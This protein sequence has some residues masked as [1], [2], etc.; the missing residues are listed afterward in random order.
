MGGVGEV[1][2]VRDRPL[3]VRLDQDAAGKPGRV[4]PPRKMLHP[5]GCRAGPA[6]TVSMATVRSQRSISRRPS[7]ETPVAIMMARETT[8]PLPLA[9]Q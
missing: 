1:A 4:V 7:A 5:A 2:A 9:L 3:V 6:S 8:C